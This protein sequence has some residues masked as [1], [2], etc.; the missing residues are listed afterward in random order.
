MRPTFRVGSACPLAF[1][2]HGFARRVERRGVGP[3]AV[4]AM[5]AVL[6][7]TGAPASGWRPPDEVLRRPLEAPWEAVALDLHAAWR[8]A[9]WARLAARRRDMAVVHAAD[10]EATRRSP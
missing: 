2:P 4:V 9:E 10:M 5:R 6:N 3:A 8:D 7:P 1:C